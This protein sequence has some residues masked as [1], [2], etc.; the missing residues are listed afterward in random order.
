MKKSFRISLDEYARMQTLEKVEKILSELSSLDGVTINRENLEIF[1]RVVEE[2]YGG[3]NEFIR[4]QLGLSD[5]RRDELR[6]ACTSA[7]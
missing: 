7:R 1:Y 3:M 4:N 2:S 5:E 6:A